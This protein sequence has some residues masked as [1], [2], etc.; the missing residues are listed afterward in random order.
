VRSFLFPICCLLLIAIVNLL[1]HCRILGLYNSASTLQ[2]F[3]M[4][5]RSFDRKATQEGKDKID[6]QVGPSLKKKRVRT[7]K[8]AP[9]PLESDTEAMD[10]HAGIMV[11]DNVED[12]PTR[13]RRVKPLAHLGSAAT[14]GMQYA[15]NTLQTVVSPQWRLNRR[16][17]KV[18]RDQQSIIQDL[19]ARLKAAEDARA[20]VYTST[21]PTVGNATSEISPLEAPRTYV[22]R[23]GQ[24]HGSTSPKPLSPV[25]PVHMHI[26]MEPSPS[27]RM[28]EQ[29]PPELVEGGRA[30]VRGRPVVRNLLGSKAAAPPSSTT[31]LQ[32][33]N[34]GAA[35]TT[36]IPSGQIDV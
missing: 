24:K 15:S 20:E 3:G 13:Q 27:R 4:V 6:P 30:L 22:H 14:T 2:F 1:L 10:A 17:S 23:Q 33:L 5:K 8:D 21:A 12:T 28:R 32:K 26:H 11:E 25:P 9:Q 31:P 35:T 19:E 29:H 36:A 16:V 34:G 18:I 7:L